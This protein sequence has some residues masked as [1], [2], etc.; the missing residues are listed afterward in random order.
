MNI[1]LASLCKSIP[2]GIRY[3]AARRQFGESENGKEL[4]VIEYQMQVWLPGQSL[5]KQWCGCVDDILQ[6]MTL[7][8]K[9]VLPRQ[10]LVPEL[11][12]NVKSH[13]WELRY[14]VL[15]LKHGNRKYRTHCCPLLPN[16]LFIYLF[17]HIF[18]AITVISRIF[19]SVQHPITRCPLNIPLVE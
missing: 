3:S 16:A 13:M 11:C 15:P 14:E 10:N 5:N 18:G 7:W 8:C 4:A 17:F 1:C 9:S 19:W 2:I 12:R 6:K